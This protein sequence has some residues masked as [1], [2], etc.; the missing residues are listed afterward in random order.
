MLLQRLES[1]L[2]ANPSLGYVGSAGSISIAATTSAYD[3]LAQHADLAKTL[4]ALAAA[5]FGAL[6]GFYTYRIQ[7]R[8]FDK[9]KKE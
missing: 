1:A 2:Q 4:F 8:T 6:A 5:V 7:R 3:A 9:L